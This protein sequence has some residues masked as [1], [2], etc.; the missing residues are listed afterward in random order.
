MQRYRG[1]TGTLG[2]RA[3]RRAPSDCEL[4]TQDAAL[5]AN[6]RKDG[7]KTDC[8]DDA[9]QEVPSIN[10]PTYLFEGFVE[11]RQRLAAARSIRVLCSAEDDR[12]WLTTSRSDRRRG[13]GSHRSAT[14]RWQRS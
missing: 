5:P 12:P 3:H 8:S 4:W 6:L 1:D 14:K 2:V 9:D 10:E 13:S 7:G 11:H